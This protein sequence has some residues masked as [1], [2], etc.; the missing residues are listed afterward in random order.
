[1][2]TAISVRGVS[3]Q[4]GEMGEAARVRALAD[5][6]LDVARGELL[7]LIGPSGCG[8]STLLKVIGGLIAPTTGT[9]TVSG[10]PVRGPMPRDL[11]IVFQESALFPWNTVFENV[12]LG[13]TFQGVHKAERKDRA[14]RALEAVGL[15]EFADYYPGQLS[16]GMRQRAALAR[17][18]SLETD[19]LL[20][21]EPF[22]ALDEQTRMVLGEDLSVLL[23]RTRKT[24]VFVTHSL[25]EAV[26]LADRVAVFSARPGTIKQIITVDEPHPRKSSF[27]TAPKFHALRDQLYGLLH[28]EIRKAMSDSARPHRPYEEAPAAGEGRA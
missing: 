11:A 25:G 15:A 6:S 13:M 12:V 23:S 21:D 16:G 17:A 14:R 7:C 28:D 8:K 5:T 1:M 22:G 4:F 24:I 3:H 19:V 26:F 18:L 20:M 9:A 2:T 27:M 10:K